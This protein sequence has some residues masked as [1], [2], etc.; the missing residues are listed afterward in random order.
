MGRKGKQHTPGF[1]G[2]TVGAMLQKRS[3]GGGSGMPKASGPKKKK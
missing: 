1:S 2:R 3:S